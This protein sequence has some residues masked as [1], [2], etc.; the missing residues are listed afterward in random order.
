MGTVKMTQE[1][2]IMFT[3]KPH[4]YPEEYGAHQEAWGEVTIL[5]K[6]DQEEKLLFQTQNDLAL[7]A[8]WFVENQEA[9]CQEEL[10]VE[11]KTALPGESLAKALIRLHDREE[12]EIDEVD[13]ELI[14]FETLREYLLR[15][16]LYYGMEGSKMENIIIGCCNGTGEIS[17]RDDGWCYTFDMGQFIRDFGNEIKRFLKEYLSSTDDPAAHIRVEGIL[18]RVEIPYVECC[19]G[20]H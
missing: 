2:R 16:D 4:P 10:I 1:L 6:V 15:H 12:F 11:G 18:S 7:L 19:R 20:K 13:E 17:H 14:W 8:E 3:R 5:V 9:I